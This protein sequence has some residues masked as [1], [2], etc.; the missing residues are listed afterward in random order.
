MKINTKEKL[1]I[2]IFGLNAGHDLHILP[3]GTVKKCAIFSS[4][5]DED[6][7][8]YLAEDGTI[9][10]S[11]EDVTDYSSYYQALGCIEHAK[12]KADDLFLII[13]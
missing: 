8:F 4:L 2:L 7:N 12:Q 5:D 9:T 6:I 3:S 11:K 13:K 1:Q 10:A